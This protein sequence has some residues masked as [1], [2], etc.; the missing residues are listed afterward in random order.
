V[1]GKIAWVSDQTLWLAPRSSTGLTGP[2]AALTLGPTAS[3]R[4]PV[5]L[6]ASPQP[7]TPGPVLAL[8]VDDQDVST[9]HILDFQGNELGAV[10]RSGHTSLQ[11]LAGGG[12]LVWPL[13]DLTRDA[14]HVALISL[15]TLDPLYDLE[16]P[17]VPSTEL[18]STCVPSPLWDTS[19]MISAPVSGAQGASVSRSTAPEVAG[20]AG[21]AVGSPRPFGDS[22]NSGVSI[23]DPLACADGVQ[24]YLES[25]SL[26][27]VEL[28]GVA[29]TDLRS[30]AYGSHSG[31]AFF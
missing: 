7:R 22:R 28:L 12:V 3:A 10:T 25:V 11:P 27:G 18:P 2:T 8:A 15:D 23:V 19:G 29:H 14:G 17:G 9:L 31:Q 24:R 21:M 4:S 1:F 13:H 6:V 30:V 20:G 16:L 26:A 5:V